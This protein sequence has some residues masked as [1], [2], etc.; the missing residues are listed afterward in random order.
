[1]FDH[2]PS[3]RALALMLCLTFSAPALAL[4]TPSP[5]ISSANLLKR[6]LGAQAAPAMKQ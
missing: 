5:K 4:E 2:L 1:M 6:F 3:R